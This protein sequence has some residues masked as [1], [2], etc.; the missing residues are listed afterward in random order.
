MTHDLAVSEIF[1][2]TWQGEGPTAGR[3]AWFLRL[4]GCNLACSWCDTPFTWDARRY[5]LRTE[6]RNMPVDEIESRLAGAPR[7]V[8]TGGEPLLQ[9]VALEPLIYALAGK[10]VA[11]EVETNGTIPPPSWPVS[12]RVSPKL[13]NSGNP[14]A[15][16]AGW[17]EISDV[18]FKFVVSQVAD[19]AEI[20]A[21]I[22]PARHDRIWVMPEGV[23]LEQTLSTARAIAGDVLQRGWSLTLRQHVLLWGDRRGV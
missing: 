9:R 22:P 11:L 6:L 20:D 5:D 3:V 2:P 15:L 17:L 8:V 21:L 19:L 13:R 4:G 14:S 1:G 23:T 16:S 12:Y 7:V 18:W 10:G